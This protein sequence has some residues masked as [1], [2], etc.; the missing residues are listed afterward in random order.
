MTGGRNDMALSGLA[1]SPQLKSIANELRNQY[2]IVYARPESLIPPQK[3]EVAV[4]PAGLT[5][6]GTPAKVK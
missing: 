1:V 6:R 3:I 5:A 4:K 2:R